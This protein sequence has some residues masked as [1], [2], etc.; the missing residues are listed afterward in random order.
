MMGLRIGFAL[1]ISTLL[2]SGLTAHPGL[3]QSDFEITPED[4]TYTFGEQLTFEA[5]LG[6]TDQVE[7]VLLFIQPVDDS[8]VQVFPV[9]MDDDGNLSLDIDLRNTPLPGFADIR[10]WYQVD[11]MNGKAYQSNVSYFTYLDNRYQWKTLADERFTIYWYAGDLSFGEELLN[12]ARVGAIEVQE[13]LDI[14]LP[15]GVD[16]YVYDDVQKMQAVLPDAGQYWFAGHADPVHGVVLTTLPPGHDQ[17]LEME[18]QIPHELMHV[19]LSYTDS[20]A[21]QNYPIWFNEGLASM[22]ELYPDPEYETLISNAFESGQLIPMAD[23]C[24]SFPSDPRQTLLAYAQSASFTQFLFDQYGKPGFNRLMAAYASGL[25]CERGVEEALGE[26]LAGLEESWRQ[27]TFTG[28]TLGI[29]F[30]E[31]LPWLLLLLVLL[32]VPIIMAGIVIRKR[33]ARSEYE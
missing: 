33:S 21:Y 28:V 12:V 19:A 3:A 26:S 24:Q 10:Y 17:R 32:A 15:E 29:A 14:F 8:E 20:H 9:S 1:L 31:M 22:V 30:R 18:R 13:L 4:P 27:S 23:L 25:D 6:S 16:I 2:L 7:K 5:V 11:M